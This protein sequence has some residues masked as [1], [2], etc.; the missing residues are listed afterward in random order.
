M[1]DITLSQLGISAESLEKPKYSPKTL[2]KKV[3][4]AALAMKEDIIAWKTS[5]FPKKKNKQRET[6]DTIEKTRLRNPQ[7]RNRNLHSKL[8]SSTD[9]LYGERK[10]KQDIHRISDENEHS[11]TYSTSQF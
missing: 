9:K 1:T 6:I 4:P 3:S 11:K 8:Q 7:P 5:F 10:E 2:G